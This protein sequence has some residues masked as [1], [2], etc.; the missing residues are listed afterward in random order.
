MLYTPTQRI[1]RSHYPA[2]GRWRPNRRLT[3]GQNISTYRWAFEGDSA[4]TSVVT[5]GEGAE[6]TREEGFASDTSGFAEGVTL[7]EVYSMVD[8]PLDALDAEADEWLEVTKTPETLELVTF[9]ETPLFGRIEVGD[10]CPV[11]II[12]GHLRVEGETYRIVRMTLNADGSL[13]LSM[14]RREVLAE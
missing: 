2:R 13:T 9:P 3:L 8:S 12:D 6:S 10:W 5:L 7:E 11:D 4:N 14:N 1:L